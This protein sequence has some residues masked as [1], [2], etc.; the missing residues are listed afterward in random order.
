ML[1][2]YAALAG[3]RRYVA[4]AGLGRYVAL[5]GLGKDFFEIS[6]EMFGG[7]GELYY[8]CGVIMYLWQEYV[9]LSMYN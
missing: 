7:M 8:L 2:R 5:A 3:L 1:R 4:L 6:S 9:T